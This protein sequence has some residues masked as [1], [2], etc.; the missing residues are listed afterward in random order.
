MYRVGVVGANLYGRIY[1]E[2]FRKQPDVAVVGM[3]PAHGD[4]EEDMAAQLGIQPYENVTQLLDD[5]KLEV[6]CIC[7]GTAEHAAHT[8]LAA[9][10]GVHVLCERPIA[11]S[12]DEAQ[13]MT[14]A[15][16]QAN[17][18]FMVGHV[19]R[20]WPEYVVARELLA[21]GE[22]GQI[23]SMTTSR[24]SGTLSDP[25]QKRLLDPELGL[26]ALEALIHDMDYLNW[27]LGTPQAIYAQGLK[28][29]SGAW[30]QLQSLMT[31]SGGAQA[32][33]ESSYLVPLTF[34][35]SMYLR[36]LAEKGTLVFDFRGAL[37]DRGTSTRRLVLT[38][39]GR[40][41]EVLEV[42]DQDA[43]VEEVAY[44]LKCVEMEKQ[45]DLGSGSQAT[46]ALAMILAGSQA[47]AQEKRIAPI[48]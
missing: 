39:V 8:L 32:Q 30:G 40:S 37:S 43:Y 16:S 31:F 46:E 34:P 24:V 28:A 20:F 44:F 33:A 14:T 7:S 3:A 21:D 42:P 35:L 18:T 6:L 25:W 22:L 5:N 4:Y 11:M 17:V 19:L 9:E 47:G 2:A 10:A 36:V 38:R 13:K 12:L 27:L 26:G 23:L 29:A 45:P 1:A 15:V 48:L 41:P